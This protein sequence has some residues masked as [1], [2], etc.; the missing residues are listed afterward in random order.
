MNPELDLSGNEERW[1][2][3]N[4]KVNFDTPPT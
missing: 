3:T 1:V 2:L 4:E